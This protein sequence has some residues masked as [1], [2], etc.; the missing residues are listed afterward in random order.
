LETIRGETEIERGSGTRLNAKSKD[1]QND[2][3]HGQ[4]NEADDGRPARFGRHSGSNR[5]LGD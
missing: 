5:L 3:R 2:R 4:K 1:P